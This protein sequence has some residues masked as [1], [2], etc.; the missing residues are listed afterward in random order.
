MRAYCHDRL[1]WLL[2]PDAPEC[3]SSQEISLELEATF[4][5][6]FGREL[7]AGTS[8]GIDSG[9]SQIVSLIVFY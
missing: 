2:R 6:Y 1:L 7:F 8:A 5:E 9:R 4:S 3:V